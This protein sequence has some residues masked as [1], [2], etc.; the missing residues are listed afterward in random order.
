L[1]AIHAKLGESPSSDFNG[2]LLI[3]INAEHGASSSNI[4]FPRKMFIR[5][6]Q[7]SNAVFALSRA[8]VLF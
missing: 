7:Q 5:T 4:D 1:E 2:G 8:L 6:V 3:F